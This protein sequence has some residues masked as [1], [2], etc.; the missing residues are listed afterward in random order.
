MRE[1]PEQ[2]DLLKL[3]HYDAE[4]GLLFWRNRGVPQWDKRWAG[5][6][7]FNI[8]SRG[9]RVGVLHGIRSIGAHRVAY[10][11]VYGIDAAEI[12]HINGNRS[13]NRIVN[14]RSVTATE[15]RRNAAM[16]K[17]NRSG[18]VGVHWRSDKNKWVAFITLANRY[19]FL[20]YFADKQDA[21]HCRQQAEREHGFHENHGRALCL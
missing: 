4:T 13:D 2:E 7:A 9:Y 16:P 17:T 21:I 5:K 19:T 8:P 12:D 18:C 15:N 6:P 14:L 10:K 1:L 11:Y 20:G 3:V